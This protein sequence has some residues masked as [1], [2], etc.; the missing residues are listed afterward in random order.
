MVAKLHVIVL[1][2]TKITQVAAPGAETPAAGTAP[3]GKGKH[4]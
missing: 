2:F 3:A 1:D 4:P